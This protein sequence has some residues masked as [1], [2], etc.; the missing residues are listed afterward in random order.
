MTLG[1]SIRVAAVAAALAVGC[2]QESKAPAADPAA[3]APVQADSTDPLWA[4]APA[5]VDVALVIADRAAASV[6]TGLVTVVH[7]LEQSP[8]TAQLAREIR[9]SLT[10][11]GIDLL[12]QAKLAAVGID[13]GR[14]AAFFMSK[15]GPVAVLPVGDRAKLVAAVGGK[16]EAG[17]D[18]LKSD[19]VCKDLAGRYACATQA[20]LLDQLGKGGSSPVASWPAELRGHIEVYASPAQL[21]GSPLP[22]ILSGTEGVRVSA[23]LERGGATVRA[24]LTGK[25]AGPLAGAVP[26]KTRLLADL[27]DQAPSGLFVLQGAALWKTFQSRALEGVPPMQLPG[28]AALDEVVRS[29]D[30]DI[31]AYA[32]S[33]A[34]ERG[35]VRIGLSSVEPMKKLLAACDQ[36]AA[37]APPGVTIAKKGERCAVGVGRA[38][39]GMVGGAGETIEAELWVD[40]KLGALVAGFGDQAGTSTARP[41]LPTLAREILDQ[42]HL[43]AMWAQGSIATTPSFHGSAD[44]LAVRGMIAMPI[45]FWLHRL[46]ELGLAVR[47]RDDGI[48]AALRVR[49][50]WANPDPLVAEADKLFEELAQGKADVAR[51]QA[52]A[53]RYPDAPLAHDVQAG[54]AGFVLLAAPTGTIAAI[55]I[56]AFVGYQRRAKAAEASV[57]LRR[58]YQSAAEHVAENG[59]LPAESSP[60]TPPAGSCCAG[61]DH[62]CAPDPTLW[63][64][65][66]WRALKF[67]MDDPHDYSYQYEV[68]ADGKSFT[69]R[70][71]GDLDC[72][73]TYSSFELKGSLGADGAI[74]LA[75]PM[76]M[77]NEL[78]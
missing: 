22:A 63:E 2:K 16:S 43:F 54:G 11:A 18:R 24:H 37:G 7:A 19:M 3:G 26:A 15:T 73:G 60:M 61:P 13:L 45:L 33:G 68:A 75:Q 65:G 1:R 52:L 69:V 32:P 34:P 4:L 25:P 64:G 29:V 48:H 28:G 46:N 41:P 10:V 53:A 77:T 66:P 6:Q 72:D 56:P 40:E 20:A 76:A 14:G 47:V 9:E 12:D 74:S 8:V 70:A 55:A 50:L 38:A 78:E 58:L 27:A 44:L 5:D 57:E 36:L 23:R 59:S 62:R 42:P 30:G 67:S 71:A 35:F 17:V 49:T 21:A 51:V 39:L 31:V